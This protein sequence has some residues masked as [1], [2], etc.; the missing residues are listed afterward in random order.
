MIKRFLKGLDQKYLK[1]CMYAAITVLVTVIAGALAFSTGPFWSKL[2]AI[3]TA[4]LKPIIIGGIICYL[5]LPVVNR[6]ERLFNRDKEHG[7]ARSVSVLLT[8]A[9]IAAAVILVLAMIV[10]SIYKNVGALN[11]ESI[12]NLY[13]TLKEEYAEVAKYLEQVMESFNISSGRI[14]TIL[15]S[16]AGAIENFFSGLLFGVIFAVYFLLDKKNSIVSYWN[17]AFRLIFGDKA[18]E[19]LRFFMKDADNAFSGYIRGQMVD[20]A[21]VGVMASI[22]LAVAGVPYAVLIGVC[23]GFGNLIPYFGPVVGYA[24]VV[25]VCL[26]SGNFTK[27]L[28]GLVIIAVIMFVD[29]NII[30]PRLLS[31]NVDVHPLLVVAALLGGGVLGGIAGMLIAVPTAALLKLQF[32]RY[33]QKLEDGRESHE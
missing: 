9:V 3:F 14:S 15:K 16:A 1:I 23:I 17:R 31:E 8:F 2:W 13:T 29:G 7:W 21:I 26:T 27:M 19:Q 4:V 32:D 6:L 5:L 28:I 11:I 10:I 22:A 12:T 24:A 30:N 25:I 20:A 33:L 18:Q